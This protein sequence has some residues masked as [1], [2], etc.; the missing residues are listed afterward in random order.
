VIRDSGVTLR[1]VRLEIGEP[2]AV[3]PHRSNL[4]R[5]RQADDAPAEKAVGE[6]GGHA[7]VVVFAD[8]RRGDSSQEASKIVQITGR[9]STSE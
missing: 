4:E 8:E 7:A 6:I 5:T 3:L 1:H 9:N 2:A